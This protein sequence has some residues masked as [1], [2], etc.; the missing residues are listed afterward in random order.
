M[1][2]PF[3]GPPSQ[4]RSLAAAASETTNLYVELIENKDDQQKNVASLYLT[5][6][7][8]LGI[9]LDIANNAVAGL[10]SGGGDRLFVAQGTDLVEVDDGFAFVSRTTYTATIDGNPIQMF[11]NGNQLLI[12]SAGQ[13]YIDNGAGP[14]ACR[15]LIEGDVDT[16]SGGAFATVNWDDGDQFTPEINGVTILVNGSPVVATYI[17]ATQITVAPDVGTL[18]DVPYSAAAGDLVT[19]LTGAYLDG[20]FFVQ[21]PQGGTPDL[22]RQVNFSD[23]NDGTT[24]RGLNFIT[25]E[26][27]ADYIRS[28]LVDS[29]VLY[30][31]GEASIEGWQ[32]DPSSG[33]P[34]R[35]PGAMVKFG[36]ISQWGP[37][38][39]NGKVYF[40]GGDDQG[41]TIAY[42]IDGGFPVRISTHAEEEQWQQLGLGVNCISYAYAEE[43]HVF[44]VINFGAQ[45]WAWDE[46]SKTWG[47]RQEWNGT[48]FVGY[49]TFFH[50]YISNWNGGQGVHVT[51][52][53]PLTGFVYQS[54][55]DF[56][57]D[58]GSDMAWRKAI[59]YR[60]GAGNILYFG[61]MTLEMEVGT[62]ASMSVPGVVTRDYSDDR[63]NTF[64]NPQDALTGTN[65]QW[66]NGQW[67]TRVFWATGGSSYMRVWRF[68]GKGQSK[69]ALIDLE[70][71]ETKG[72]V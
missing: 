26:G 23:V 15:F 43:G 47:L 41:G 48:A 31:F 28:I 13:A 3:V 32:N 9:D 66:A 63:G 10:W 54:S 4:L 60:Y 27:A 62:V 67:A 29:E 44:W 65:Q 36:S 14:V 33:L 38:A 45:A 19:A 61:R 24:W 30:L 25:K 68:F 55:V 57:D 49:R 51:A 59:P 11:G 8:H 71:D 42:R 7:R 70:C 50:T 34:V 18:T 53:D 35:I 21:R 1:R 69:I 22:G 40:V 20:S 37:W 12:I 39:I 16:I 52:G 5:P 58:N 2:I 46:T 56:Y 64:V 17:S 6:G 72:S